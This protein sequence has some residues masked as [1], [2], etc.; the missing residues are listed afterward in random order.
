MT[1][2]TVTVKGQVTIPKDVRESLGL[3]D[4]D[5]VAFVAGAN[6]AIL[7]PIKGDLRDLRGALKGMSKGRVFDAG[8][9]RRAA[10]RHVSRR[11][12]VHRRNSAD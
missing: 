8:A 9:A 11:Y 6:R 5:R 10:K 12:A 7:F 4:G 3:K 1:Q 2:T